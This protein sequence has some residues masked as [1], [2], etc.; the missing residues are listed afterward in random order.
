MY[1]IT[2]TSIQISVEMENGSGCPRYDDPSTSSTCTINGL[3]N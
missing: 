1:P 2:N 3:L